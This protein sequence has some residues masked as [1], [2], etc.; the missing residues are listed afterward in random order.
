ME[1][2]AISKVILTSIE[3]LSK[4]IMDEHYRTH[5]E[6]L[7]LYNETQQEKS[8]RDTRHNLNYLAESIALSYP[9]VFVQYVNW[10]CLLLEKLNFN[11]LHLVQHFDI[12]EKVLLKHLPQDA[13]ATI[14]EY[15]TKAKMAIQN[16]HLDIP[17]FLTEDNQYFPNAKEY[18]ESLLKKSRLVSAEI[19]MKLV[20]KEVSIE[21]IY[22]K[23][24][25][26][27]QYEVGRLWQTNQ[28]SV[29]EEHYATA[30]TQNVMSQLYPY[31]FSTEKHGKTFIS[32]CVNDE[33]HELGIRM[34]SD[35]YELRGWDTY[36]LGANTPVEGI[37]QMVNKKNASILGIS[38]TLTPHLQRVENLITKVRERTGRSLKIIVG[39]Q[40]FSSVPDSWKQINADFYA[41]NLE[42]VLEYSQIM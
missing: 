6:L 26:P 36:F 30:V 29:A 3:N 27:V 34:V 31:I 1:N 33:L 18:L 20:E 4:E 24:F 11:I 15:I 42:T 40:A 28:I 16:P 22:L 23:I 8:L 21:D 12:M 37:I 5:K 38:A 41:P 14:N 2:K 17:S 19:I 13:K 9:D 10:L 7:T 35:F 32:C 25:Q 39:G